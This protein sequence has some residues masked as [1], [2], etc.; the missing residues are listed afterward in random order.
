MGAREHEGLL[1]IAQSANNNNPMFAGG[2]VIT[3]CPLSRG[4][5]VSPGTER[6]S[7]PSG[8]G[9]TKDKIRFLPPT[10]PLASTVLEFLKGHPLEDG[11]WVTH[12]IPKL[13]TWGVQLRED[14]RRPSA[15]RVRERNGCSGV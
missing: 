13:A 11:P 14:R 5:R 7:S 1:C 9:G 3:P 8:L 10:Q 15:Q 6:A 4:S 12:G 2:R